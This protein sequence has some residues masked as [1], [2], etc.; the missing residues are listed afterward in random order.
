MKI[1]NYQFYSGII[2]NYNSIALKSHFCVYMLPF[3]HTTH[4]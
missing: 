4:L 2:M 1:A 3:Q